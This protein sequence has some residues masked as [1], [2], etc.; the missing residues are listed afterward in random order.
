MFP[1]MKVIFSLL[2]LIIPL[3]LQAKAPDST[4]PLPRRWLYLQTSLFPEAQ[5]ARTVSLLERLAAEG[6]TG[7]VFNDYKFMRWDSLPAG[8]RENWREL[9]DT[10]R[11]LKL[12]LIAAVMPMGYSNSLLS[13]DPHLA[14][15]L[16]VRGATFIVRN[17]ALVPHE[18]LPLRN[19]GFE[20]FTDHSPDGWSFTDEPGAIS[21]MDSNV[22]HEGRASLRMQD[23]AK[24]E[25]RH[26]HARACQ[27]LRLQ[28]F[29]N[30]RVSVAVKTRDWVAGE[31]RIMV[32]DDKG[33]RL[34]FQTP[35]FERTQDWKTIDITFNTL[36]STTV[37][38]YL[39]TWAGA[40]GAIWWDNV[41]IEP[42]G[43]MNILRRP[44]TPLRLYSE[45]GSVTYQ[46]GRDAERIHD[47]L[48][49][50]DPWAG[51][52]S[53]WHALPPIR[54][55]P[56]SRLR[57]GQRVRA[58]YYHTTVIH[59]GQVPC[60]MSEPAVYEILTE[61]IRQVC[62]AIQPDGYMMMHDEIRIQG[63]D[64]SC[65]KQGGDPARILGN[66][67]RHCIRIIQTADPGKPLFIWS[68]MFDPTH[69]ASRDGSYYLVKGQGP[70]AGAWEALPPEVTVVTWQMG[71]RTRRQS[72]EHFAQ[73]GHK[74][75]LAGY[76]DGDPKMIGPWL[77]DARGIQGIEG[78]M[79]TTWQGN[80]THT[81]EFLESARSR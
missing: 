3:V 28:P 13:R 60:C 65:I 41:R 58:D 48:M 7:I 1:G 32:L 67:V 25:P 50:M 69:N 45:D 11:R 10:C 77:E 53:S 26:R 4:A 78:V 36:D 76:Y 35:V 55:P 70:W 66:N 46:E 54:L 6:Y 56:G 44:G 57:E 47:P 37:K 33:R 71:P 75:I 31:T 34:N 29:H 72:L 59:D 68:D 15:G 79:Y 2:A 14:E 52:Y 49:G 23:V 40:T 81:R 42:A 18:T 21:F 63:W 9:R 38:L 80:F 5:M 62:E 39:G 64:H 61:H 30:Y 20:S 8:Y 12:E 74:Q 51:D 27:T 19:G 24:H 73:R 16:P 43:F 17:G 22:V